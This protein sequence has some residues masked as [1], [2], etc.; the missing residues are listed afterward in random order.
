MSGI[1]SGGFDELAG[2]LARLQAQFQAL[3]AGHPAPP[4]G[5]EAGAEAETTTP[6]DPAA[7][8]VAWHNHTH[9]IDASRG[10]QRFQSLLD[11]FAA[12]RAAMT[13]PGATSGPAVTEGAKET[14]VAGGVRKARAL[15][16]G[17]VPKG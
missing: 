3:G 16:K 17:K 2:D 10:R 9:G 8:A 12:L 13:Q 6:V 4:V 11:E 5:E 1:G 14:D 7:S 15:P